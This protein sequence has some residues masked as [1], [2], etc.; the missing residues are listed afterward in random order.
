[1]STDPVLSPFPISTTAEQMR[2]DAISHSRIAEDMAAS[3]KPR[4]LHL[5][6]D[7]EEQETGFSYG[8][9]TFLDADYKFLEPL[10]CANVATLITHAWKDVEDT[11]LEFPADPEVLQKRLRKKFR[12]LARLRWSPWADPG[13]EVESE[14]HW[15]SSSDVQDTVQH[16]YMFKI[17][18]T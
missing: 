5:W 11:T 17:G 1:L 9:R 12:R 6:F 4:S 8:S 14:E 3:G 16:W 2:S 18:S 7:L 10:L 15:T 13:P